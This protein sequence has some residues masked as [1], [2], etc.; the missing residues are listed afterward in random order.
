MEINIILQYVSYRPNQEVG[1]QINKN[2]GI[3]SAMETKE[4][5]MGIQEV[6]KTRVGLL[7]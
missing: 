3:H 7:L 5:E 2:V 1:P 4:H 6:T